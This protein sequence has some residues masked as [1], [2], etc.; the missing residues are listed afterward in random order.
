[1]FVGLAEVVADLG[2]SAAFVI[3]LIVVAWYTNFWGRVSFL[4]CCLFVVL[5]LLVLFCCVLIVCYG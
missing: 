5:C 1:M 2:F 3:A 4:L